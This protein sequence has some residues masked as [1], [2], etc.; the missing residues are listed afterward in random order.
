M[1]RKVLEELQEGKEI[2]VSVV[3]LDLRVTLV[4]KA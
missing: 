2:E 4:Y 1:E 3:Q